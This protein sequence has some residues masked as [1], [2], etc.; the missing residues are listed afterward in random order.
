MDHA[1]VEGTL[2]FVVT[3]RHAARVHTLQRL[4]TAWHLTCADVD[5]DVHTDR[6]TTHHD[7]AT[8]ASLTAHCWLPDGELYLGNDAG[9]LMVRIR[10]RISQGE[11]QRRPCMTG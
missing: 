10:R 3:G 4:R 8:A 6:H 2:M 7:A 5:V 1:D 11:W 9:E